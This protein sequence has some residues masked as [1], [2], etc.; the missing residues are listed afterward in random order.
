MGK[1]IMKSLGHYYTPCKQKQFKCD[2]CEKAYTYK[3]GLYQHKKYE[4]GKEPQFQCPHC[5]YKSK[6]KATM[7]THICNVHLGNL[8][9]SVYRTNLKIKALQSQFNLN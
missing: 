1:I 9:N 4:C 6:Q 8:S 3:A 2:T 7:K 5:P